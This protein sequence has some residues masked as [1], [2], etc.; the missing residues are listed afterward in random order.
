MPA[1]ALTNFEIQKYY[2]T[3]PKLKGV[4]SWNNSSKIKDWL[5]LINLNE[6]KSIG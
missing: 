6:Y 1:Y 4:Y 5:C 3:K 2:Q